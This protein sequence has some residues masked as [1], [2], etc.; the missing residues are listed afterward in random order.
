MPRS[1]S[2]SPKSSPRSSRQSS[3]QQPL[4]PADPSGFT[5]QTMIFLRGLAKNNDREWFEARRETYQHALRE[6]MLAIIASVNRQMESFAPLHIKAPEKTVLRNYRGHPL[7]K[8]QAALQAALRSMVGTRRH[9]K[10]FRRGLLLS[11]VG[12]AVAYRCWPLHARPR[13][14][15]CRCVATC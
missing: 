14:R 11:S 13:R 9:G 6:P 12:K 10:D 1:I 5:A 8:K 2:V 15:R 7:F 3:S 4:P